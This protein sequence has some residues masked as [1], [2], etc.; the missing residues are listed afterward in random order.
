[1]AKIELVE[2]IITDLHAG[3]FI[4]FLF[5]NFTHSWVARNEDVDNIEQYSEKDSF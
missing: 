4:A 2:L 3:N 1:M 5:W